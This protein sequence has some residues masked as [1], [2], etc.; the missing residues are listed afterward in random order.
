[1]VF[2]AGE[3]LPRSPQGLQ[4]SVCQSAPLLFSCSVVSGSLRPGGLQHARLPCPSL[5][6]RVCSNSCPLSRCCH[7]II[8]SSVAPFCSCSQSF[9]ASRSF[10]IES[11]LRMRWPKCWSFSFSISPFN[12]YSGLI[13]FTIDWFDLL[14]VQETL[15]ILLQ[16]HSSKTSILWHSAFFVVQLSHLYMTTGKIIALLDGPLLAK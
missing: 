9:P 10:P 12:E 11:V 6:P 16:H 3:L 8:S 2:V 7:P 5:S 14:A 15:K 1:M 4:L 13:S